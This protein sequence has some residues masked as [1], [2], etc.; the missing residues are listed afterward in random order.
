MTIT[1]TALRS[2]CI[3]HDWFTH[4]SNYQYGK[5]F[6]R[7]REGAGPE[8]LAAMIWICSENVTKKEIM[9]QLSPEEPEVNKERTDLVRAMEK[10]ARTVN[11]EEVFYSWLI[12]GVAD[13]DIK[14]DTPDSDLEYY[15]EDDNFSELMNTFLELMCDAKDDGGLYADGI[16]S[17]KD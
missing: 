14:N 6:D 15:T 8:E 16:V 4:G 17:S 11:N 1:A 12:A 10:I 5:L 9:K 2:L 13:G 7:A 3:E